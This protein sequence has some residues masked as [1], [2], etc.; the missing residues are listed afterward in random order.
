MQTRPNPLARYKVRA[1]SAQPRSTVDTPPPE[2]GEELI[3]IPVF[4]IF[5]IPRVC[6]IVGCPIWSTLMYT[7]GRSL[8]LSH[9]LG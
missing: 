8:L 5:T 1:V 2:R 3:R 7:Q 9:R 6:I 4:N